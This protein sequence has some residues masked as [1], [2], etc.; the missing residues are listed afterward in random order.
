MQDAPTSA[1]AVGGSEDVTVGY[2]DGS[3]FGADRCGE[4][5]RT[6]GYVESRIDMD[7]VVGWLVCTDGEERGRDYRLH[8]GRNFVGRAAAMDVIICDDGE[9][10]RENHCSLVY[11][12]LHGEY[13]LAPGHGTLTYK[14]GE[15][16]RET[17]PLRD[18][19]EIGIGDS[20]F[21]FVAFCKDGR[22]WV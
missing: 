9:V 4:D 20:T 22:R 13:L 8:S 11:D 6:V 1:F 18:G 7:P 19:D 17:V 5:E 14:G 3:P 2:A 21:V 10:S 12:P 16:V 15:P